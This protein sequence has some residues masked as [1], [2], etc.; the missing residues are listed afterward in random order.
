MLDT[1]LKKELISKFA[2]KEEDTGSV[3]V[4]CALI[5]E[6]VKILTKHL[7]EHKK[8]FSSRRGLIMLIAKRRKLLN[9]IK[10]LSQQRYLDLVSRL[11]IKK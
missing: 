1:F 9:Y 3:E 4:Q 11:G 2:T 7:N 10:S 5:T 8:D 6:R